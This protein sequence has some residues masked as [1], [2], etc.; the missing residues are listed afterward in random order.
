MAQ[1]TANWIKQNFP[2]YAGWNDSA[3]ILADYKSTGGSGKTGPNSPP[4]GSRPSSGSSTGSSG[5]NAQAELDLL[6]QVAR[7]VIA[8]EDQYANLP[9]IS[10]TNEEM[11]TFLQKAIDQVTPY[12]EQR[13]KEI[14]SGI[15]EGKI[16]TAE[17]LLINLREA[18]LQIATELKGFDID[19]AETEE[20]FVNTLANVTAKEGE[21][22]ELNR[23]QWMRRVDEA[24]SSQVE[25]GTLTSG[26]GREQISNLQAER[27]LFRQSIERSAQ[28]SK[29]SLERGKK[30]DLQRIQIARE[31]AEKKRLMTI[32]TQEDF[33][34]KQSQLARDAGINPNASNLDILRARSERNVSVANPEDLTQLEEQRSQGIESRKLSLQQEELDARNIQREAE[35]KRIA[36]EL[37]KKQ[38]EQQA[39]LNSL[40][41]Q[42]INVQYNV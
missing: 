5:L 10:L 9:G 2:G 25:S 30:Y 20:E 23:L 34:N 35:E 1:L 37:A 22:L 6:N 21:D 32:G 4:V 16:R 15:K 17:D 31:N 12:Y 11:D 42:G 19:Q 33:I 3:S 38:R 14:E 40:R 8:L 28:F 29:D 13:R 26:I 7:Q 18:D 27:D 39:R 36:S 41:S 24:R